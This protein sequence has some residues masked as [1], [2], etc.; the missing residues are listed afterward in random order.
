M[1]FKILSRIIPTKVAS[2]LV[3]REETEF[4]RMKWSKDCKELNNKIIECTFK[5][6]NW[7]FLR[8][9]SDK[10]YP[11]SYNTA[12]GEKTLSLFLAIQNH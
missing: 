7:M 9:R 12:K 8:E 11:N 3:G 4:A 1:Y 2:L 5:D 10:T 6:G